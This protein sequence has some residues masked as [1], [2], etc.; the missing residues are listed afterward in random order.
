M[1]TNYYANYLFDGISDIVMTD[2]AVQVNGSIISYVGPRNAAPP[3][4]KTVEL[5]EATIMP[6]LIDCHVHLTWCGFHRRPTDLIQEEGPKITALRAASNA[7]RHFRAGVTTVRDMG[8]SGIARDV[9]DAINK[10]IIVGPRVIACGNAI[11]Q[12]GGHIYEAGIEAD[13]PV[14]V[15]KAA[16]RELREGSDFIKMCASGGVYGKREGLFAAQYSVE[17]LK[18]GVNVATQAGTYVSV[19]AYGEEAIR[20]S[21]DAGVTRIEHGLN[22]SPKLAERMAR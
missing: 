15:A 20:N 14:E 13:G 7:T 8:S 6:G 21:L 5:G 22:L 9:R 10:G 16:R 3:A 18:A 2:G 4:D 1:K 19:H 12:T 17:E 11:V